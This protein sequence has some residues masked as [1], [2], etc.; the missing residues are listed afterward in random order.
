MTLFILKGIR[1]GLICL[2]KPL[3]E[4]ISFV[5]WF[6]NIDCFDLQDGTE[7]SES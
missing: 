4:D 7:C 6:S 5:I 1:K 2:Q 3:E